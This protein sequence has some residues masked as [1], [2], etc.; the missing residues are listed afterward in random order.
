M[1]A[2]LSSSAGV[3][4]ERS[5]IVWETGHPDGE[6]VPRT[7][8]SKRYVLRKKPPGDLLSPTAHAI[9]REFRVLAALGKHNASLPGTIRHQ[10]AVP[11]PAVYCLCE[12]KSIVGTN[13]YVMEF[14]EGRIFSDP[15]MI[16]LPKHERREW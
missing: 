7:P 2:S 14:V 4:W 12:D 1:S 6:L 15:R 16:Q 3:V 9:E 13:F 5:G 8:S 10:D 11:V